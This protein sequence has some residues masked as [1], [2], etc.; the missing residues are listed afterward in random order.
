[1]APER[2]RQAPA[3][4]LAAE[5]GRQA[6]EGGRQAPA[7]ALATE[8]GRQATVPALA[9]LHREWGLAVSWARPALG[10]AVSKIA[11]RGQVLRAASRV[12]AVREPAAPET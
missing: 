5:G 6:A 12:P 10:P 4:E 3:P 1:L 2:E 7:P 9:A 8:G 11:W